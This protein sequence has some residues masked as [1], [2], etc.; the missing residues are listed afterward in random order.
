MI[1]TDNIK[2]P[3]DYSDAD[4]KRAAAKKLSTDIDN[5]KSIK[6]IR[7]SIDARKTPRYV[8]SVAADLIDYSGIHGEKYE[9]TKPINIIRK[10]FKKRPVIAG[11]GPAGIFAALVL[12]KS[13]AEPIILE[14]GKSADKRKADI[15]RFFSGGVFSENSN[16]QFG[17]GGAGM[18]S[19]GKLATGIKSPYIK[20]IFETFVKCG[21][22]EEILFSAKP[23]IGS[24]VL[25]KV[26]KN[27]RRETERLGGEFR[28]ETCLTGIKLKDGKVCAALCGGEEIETDNILL[29]VGHSSRDTFGM[30]YDL[31]AEMEAKPFAVGCRIE[32]LQ[33]DI[34]AAQYGD[35][36]SLFPPADYKLSCHLASG[37]SVYTFCMCPG[38]YV[39][40]SSS[41]QGGIVT[42]GYSE[43]SRDG[44]N[45][46]S[47]LLVGISP[48]TLGGDLWAGLRLQR[49]I[50][51]KAYNITGSFKAPCQTVGDFLKGSA[52]TAFGEIRPT[53]KEGVVPSD[54]SL[55]LPRYVAEALREG[56]KI[57]AQK[58]RGFDRY[59]AL[60]TAPE[61]RSSS[62]VRIVR[63]ADMQSNI[64]GLYPAGEGSGYAGG[65][66]SSAVDGIRSALKMIEIQKGQ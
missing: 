37:L 52:S 26:V 38:G 19:D 6:I 18:F 64:K 1:K 46:N 47:A 66:T 35:S 49:E 21:A 13:G 31:G 28:F 14:R 33:K 23:H 10:K 24:D 15:D 63:D 62:P 45:A 53:Y 4:L 61:T 22:P 25:P 8:L 59:D 60:L 41:E 39:V 7:K 32:H 57:F 5:I 27:L 36:A 20:N 50:E 9:E 43:S 17:E 44:E 30:L 16:I 51:R 65:I 29:S 48:K 3:P 34:N 58:I 54:I 40:N 55:C 56:I 42:N 12:A 11:Y 2:L